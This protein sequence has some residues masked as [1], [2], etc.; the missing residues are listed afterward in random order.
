MGSRRKAIEPKLQ[1]H[2]IAFSARGFNIGEE[3]IGEAPKNRIAISVWPSAEAEQSFWNDTHDDF[4]MAQQKTLPTCGCTPWK[5]WRRNNR[6]E[7]SRLA[8]SD[9][10]HDFS[11][12]ST[13]FVE[14]DAA[15]L[16]ADA[17]HKRLLWKGLGCAGLREVIVHC[18]DALFRRSLHRVVDSLSERVVLRFDGADVRTYQG[19][20]G[21]R[22]YF[23]VG[24]VEAKDVK[25]AVVVL[26]VVLVVELAQCCGLQLGL[27]RGYGAVKHGSRFRCRAGLLSARSAR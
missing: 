15:T 2:K 1:K 27:E 22:R 3:L 11:L 10:A 5:A 19:L 4:K 6:S 26:L 17:R 8:R 9:A 25:I 12:A 14:A 13:L 21:A 23:A 7:Q 16:V 24:H 18:G 20:I